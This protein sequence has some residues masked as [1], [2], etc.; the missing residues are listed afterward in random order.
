MTEGPQEHT[1]WQGQD[2]LTLL[3]RDMA[4]EMNTSLMYLVDSLVV[5]G[6]E[7]FAI[8]AVAK[9]FC[10]QDLGHVQKL[11]ER[12]VEVEGT[13]E[14]APTQISDNASIAM[15]MEKKPETT[16]MLKDCLENELQSVIEYKGQI[17]N[18]GFTDP[19]TRLL[20]EEILADKEHQ[21]EE[22]RNL[23]GI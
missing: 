9:D 23:L 3:N 7:S 16:R 14:L 1:F 20:L 22:I 10:Q 12:I 6:V 5:K 21:V 4:N 18:I 13:P 11:A 19:A 17:M 8:K 2:V 15:R